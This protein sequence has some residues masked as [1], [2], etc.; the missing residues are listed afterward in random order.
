[1]TGFLKKRKLR[2]QFKE[3]L[4]MARHARHM[5]EDIADLKDLEALKAAEE[6]VREIVHQLHTVVKSP[7]GPQAILPY[8]Y[9]G[10]MGQIQGNSLDRRFFHRLGASL[11]DRTI[12]AT[13]GSAGCDITL[14][15]RAAVDPDPLCQPFPHRNRPSGRTH[16]LAGGWTSKCG[17]I[18][19]GR[20]RQHRLRALAP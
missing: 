18:A 13:A 9:A 19:V 11:L 6:A 7:D 16:D 10:T 8:S 20:D 15:T 4:H 5:R 14:G 17:G 1:M 3:Y 12:C 2:K